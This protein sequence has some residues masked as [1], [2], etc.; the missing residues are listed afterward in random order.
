[1]SR[2]GDVDTARLVIAVAGVALAATV[3]PALPAARP[4]CEPGRPT[5]VEARAGP[6]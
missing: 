3:R 4:S 5:G 6:P 1:M 2:R